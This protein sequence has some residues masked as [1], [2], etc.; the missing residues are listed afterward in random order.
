MLIYVHVKR[1]N[2]SKMAQ[3]TAHNHLVLSLETL[4]SFGALSING[5]DCMLQGFRMSYLYPQDVPLWRADY[6]ELKAAEILQAH[7]KLNLSLKEFELRALLIRIITKITL[8][9]LSVGK[10]KL[11]ITIYLLFLLSYKDLPSI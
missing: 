7:E 10:D 1:H 6:F 8:Y 11:L 4:S 9:D 2:L 3:Q 5:G